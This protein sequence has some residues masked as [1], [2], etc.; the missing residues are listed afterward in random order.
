MKIGVI[1]DTHDQ[2]DLIRKAVDQLNEEEVE[3]VFH[4]GD[5]IS[6]FILYF[7]RE[8]K[9]PL[10]GVFGNN[11][12]DKFR[13]LRFK[14]RWG[15]DLDYEER[16]LEVELDS[17]RIALFHGDYPG[18]VNALVSSHQ[19]DA[20]FHGH[21]HLRVNETIDGVLSLNPGSLMKETSPTVKGASLA[22]YETKSN[23]ARHILLGGA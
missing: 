18:I 3:W 7:F 13:H 16:F 9:A 2:G 17:R 8:L 22:I 15:I 21:T 1:S 14:D 23:S 12:G 11:D 19:Y 20:L 6:P 10:R 4:C 5:W